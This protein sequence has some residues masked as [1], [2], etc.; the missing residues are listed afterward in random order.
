MVSYRRRC[1]DIMA[2]KKEL[3]RLEADIE[4][5][6]EECNWERVTDLARQRFN[7]NQKEKG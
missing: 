7:K 1:P 5:N 3:M 6:R 2:A 4:K